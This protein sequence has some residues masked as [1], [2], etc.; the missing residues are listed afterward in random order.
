MPKTRSMHGH[1]EQSNRTHSRRC[2]PSQFPSSSVSEGPNAAADEQA[3]SRSL[4][5]TGDRAPLDQG[6]PAAMSNQ[7]PT[8]LSQPCIN[9]VSRGVTGLLLWRARLL[10]DQSDSFGDSSGAKKQRA[11]K[12]GQGAAAQPTISSFFTRKPAPEPVVEAEPAREPEVQARLTP[13]S[14]LAPSV[15]STPSSTDD[16]E[17]RDDDAVAPPPA[18]RTKRAARAKRVV[19]DDEDQEDNGDGDYKGSDTESPSKSRPS[20]KRCQAPPS[21]QGT[22]PRGI[23]RFRS[24]DTPA[25][26][27]T[28]SDL[29]RR[30]KIAA[31]LVDSPVASAASSSSASASRKDVK[32]TPLEKQARSFCLFFFR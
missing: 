24:Q 31:R 12:R 32:Y 26:P 4:N 28:A 20:P 14:S 9:G 8:G 18:K 27:L 15:P 13:P 25:T 17:H 23:D 29:A 19:S 11:M 10:L 21:P 30:E 2:P 5:C 6:S 16:V 3:R 7:I 1:L 22:P